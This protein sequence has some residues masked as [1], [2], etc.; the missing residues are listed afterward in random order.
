MCLEKILFEYINSMFITKISLQS[1][2][3]HFSSLCFIVATIRLKI[4][5]TKDKL[6]FLCK[7]YWRRYNELK[8]KHCFVLIL[9]LP[10]YFM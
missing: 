7:I 2:C 5:N 1:K 10:M 8:L 9:C 4:V 6:F 3:K